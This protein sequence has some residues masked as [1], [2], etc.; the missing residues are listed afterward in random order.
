MSAM[1]ISIVNYMHELKAA[2]FTDQQ[3]EVQAR[4]MEQVVAEVKNEL[5]TKQDLKNL[6]L[7]IKKDMDVVIEKLRY[8]T[9]KFVVWTSVGVIVTLGG[10]LAKGFHWL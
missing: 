10:M 6:E 5:A 2:G 8:E 9:L 7:V 4:Q 3:S 1:S